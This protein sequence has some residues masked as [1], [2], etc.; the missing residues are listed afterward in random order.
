MTMTETMSH[1]D[2]LAASL[3]EV[4]GK[5][6]NKWGVRHCDALTRPRA[7][8]EL[9]IVKMLE[10]AIEYADHHRERYEARIGDDGVIGDAW[11]RIVRGIRDLRDGELGRIDGGALDGLLVG[12]LDAEGFDV[13]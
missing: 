8:F 11:E 3:N 5:G 4:V 7:G 1:I 12:M 6:E 13:E 10:G 9:G 2:R